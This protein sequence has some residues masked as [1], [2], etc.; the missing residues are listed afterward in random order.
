MEGAKCTLVVSVFDVSCVALYNSHGGVTSLTVPLS[1]D[2]PIVGY[3]FEEKN[4]MR[5]LMSSLILFVLLVAVACPMSHAAQAETVTL[6][7]EGDAQFEVISPEGVRVLIDVRSPDDLTAPPTEDDILLTPHTHSDHYEKDF[8]ESFPGEQLFIQAGELEAEDVSIL[9]L[10]SAHN[11]KDEFKDEGGTNYIYIIDIGDLRIV[12]FGDIGQEELTEEQLE[13]LDEVD[14]ALTQLENSYSDMNLRNNKGF[15]LMEQVKPKLIIPTHAKDKSLEA[16][17]ELW[18]CFYTK[19]TMVE[20]DP[21]VLSEDQ[22]QL[23]AMGPILGKSIGGFLL[24][25]PEWDPAAGDD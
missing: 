6:H 20:I 8:V 2:S 5:R 17:A 22:T 9:G 23:L 10:P 24:K 15:N 19:E 18:E 25:F 4:N 13:T 14:I 1:P 3:S 11:A 21:S 12:H 16:A 7:Y